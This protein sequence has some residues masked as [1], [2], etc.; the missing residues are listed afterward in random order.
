MIQKRLILDRIITIIA[1]G[2]GIYHLVY[3]QT[4]LM[5]PIQHANMHFLLALVL[6]F[7]SQIR[8][9]STI[10]QLI[11]L[12]FLIVLSLFSTFYVFIEFAE[13][14]EMRGPLYLLNNM[15]LFVGISLIFLALEASR[16]AFGIVFPIIAICFMMYAYF[17]HHLSGPLETPA[18]PVRELITAYVM[19]FMEGMYGT[20]LAISANYIY[21]FVLFGGVLGATGGGR[22]FIQVGNMAAKKM[23]GGPAVIAVISSALMGSING[24]SQAN[25]AT[26][27]AFTIPLMKRVGY[28]PH[29][30]GAIEA[31]AS[32]GGQIMPPVMGAA[33]FVMAYM[34]EMPYAQVMIAAI[35]PSLLYFFSIGVYVQLQAK[36][37]AIDARSAIEPVPLRAVLFDAPTF[38]L[39]LFVITS[40]LIMRYSPMFT[41]FWGIVLLIF[42]N[43]IQA[44]IRRE[45]GA[46]KRMVDGFVKGSISG[47][48]IAVVCAVIGPIVVTVTKTVLGLKIAGLIAIWSGGT[49]VLALLMTMVASMVIG[50]G[51][52]TMPAYVLVSL[53]ATPV[54]IKMNVQLLSA[55]MFC[56]IFAVFSSLTP[57]IAISSIPA[58]SIASASYMRTALESTKVGVVGFL[59]PYLLIFAPELM[60]QDTTYLRLALPLICS[61]AAI[62][63]LGSAIVGYLFK[64]LTV[65]TRIAFGIAA[66]LVF[67]T[68]VVD[69]NLLSVIALACVLLMFLWQRYRAKKEM[70]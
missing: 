32:T 57:P 48:G 29:Q 62:L 45:K 63:A 51:V 41:I 36:K 68:I 50:M 37:M 49:L 12:F 20:V 44:A 47:A 65:F 11:F 17:G 46:L 38:I 34:L 26:T 23:A 6:V 3:T 21:L 53:V 67:G 66:A 27:G 7:L 58:A 69:Q 55:H 22:F 5:D 56:F 24:S 13:L 16:R 15:D 28:Q 14:S 70:H 64:R 43:T 40:L 54:L 2:M 59:I 1:V 4:I 30:A 33:A 8:N 60:L 18:I 25:V 10:L 61:V 31:A 52:P 35:I 42:L 39:P 9:N 19:G